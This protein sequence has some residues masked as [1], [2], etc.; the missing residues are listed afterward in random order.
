MSSIDFLRSSSTALFLGIVTCL[1]LVT[2][3]VS[4]AG[5]QGTVAKQFNLNVN[6][7][8]VSDCWLNCHMFTT[9]LLP[10]PWTKDHINTPFNLKR[11]CEYSAYQEAMGRCLQYECKSSWD[12]KYAVEYGSVICKKAGVTMEIPI[13]PTY[14]ATAGGYYATA[15]V[16]PDTK[17]LASSAQP[18]M[19]LSRRTAGLVVASAVVLAALGAGC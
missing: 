4:A 11:N 9:D 15:L 10:A 1:M 18:S 7:R 12:V 8:D 19:S 13:D 3:S 16:K 6:G 17:V 14:T 2:S 5:G